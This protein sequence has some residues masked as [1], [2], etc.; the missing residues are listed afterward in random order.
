[1]DDE[2]FRLL[3]LMKQDFG[4]MGPHYLA[5]E[6]QEM[7][8]QDISSMSKED[9]TELIERVL[10]NVFAK[11]LSMQK[12][13]A[14]RHEMQAIINSSENNESPAKKLTKAEKTDI[15]LR[16][17]EEPKN[18]GAEKKAPEKKPQELGNE[19]F[20][21]NIET[22]TAQKIEKPKAHTNYYILVGALIVVIIYALFLH[23]HIAGLSKFGFYNSLEDSKSI[24]ALDSTKRDIETIG[25]EI[26]SYQ[27][28]S[29]GAKGAGNNPEMDDSVI[30]DIKEN[31]GNGENA[32]GYTFEGDLQGYPGTGIDGEKISASEDLGG[33]DDSLA[34]D[35]SK[36]IYT[37]SVPV[38]SDKTASG[39]SENQEDSLSIGCSP[40]IEGA[41]FYDRATKHFYGCDG[42]SWKILDN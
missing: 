29:T 4:E 6:I 21:E 3:R 17:E 2:S 7:G 5:K 8:F 36:T 1:M 12:Q 33:E 14:R 35:I 37:N 32:S 22:A 13:A 39:F 16:G 40:E 30:K 42:V 9:K 41:F 38:S 10:K 25:S 27:S 26:N 28:Q 11:N 24:Q 19:P 20:K 31:Y 18:Y 15:L 34:N 23:E